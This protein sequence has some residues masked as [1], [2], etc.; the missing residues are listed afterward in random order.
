MQIK[1]QYTGHTYGKKDE[2][3]KHRNFGEVQTAMGQITV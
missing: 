3:Q 2:A 1:Y